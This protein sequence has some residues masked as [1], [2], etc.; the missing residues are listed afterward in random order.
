MLPP[1]ISDYCSNCQRRENDHGYP[2]PSGDFRKKAS[3]H[4]ND[5]SGDRG[6]DSYEPH[7]SIIAGFAATTETKSI[8]RDGAD[9]VDRQYKCWLSTQGCNRNPTRL[10]WPR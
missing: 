7:H 6:N 1:L 4:A 8:T 10:C 2:L 9:D 5:G 3:H